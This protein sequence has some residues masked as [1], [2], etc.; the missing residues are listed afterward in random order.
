MTS[1]ESGA[2]SRME[3]DD[4]DRQHFP[5]PVAGESALL[6]RIRSHVDL[7]VMAGATRRGN[8]FVNVF[9]ALVVTLRMQISD[10]LFSFLRSS[11]E[12]DARTRH[13][14]IIE[15]VAIMLDI[16]GHV[17]QLA[18]WNYSDEQQATVKARFTILAGWGR[19]LQSSNIRRLT[20]AVPL[21]RM[22][23]GAQT[24]ITMSGVFTVSGDT[25]S[26]GLT[27]SGGAGSGGAGSGVAG[28][29]VAGS[30]GNTVSGSETSAIKIL[31]GTS[32]SAIA[33]EP[34]AVHDPGGAHSVVECPFLLALL[35]ALQ[36]DS[37]PLL[38]LA[39]TLA[40]A[41]RG[42]WSSD[43]RTFTVDRSRHIGF[44]VGWE[45]LVSTENLPSFG[46]VAVHF[47]GNAIIKFVFQHPWPL[48]RVH[49][50]RGFL[51]EAC[52]IPLIARRPFAPDRRLLAVKDRDASYLSLALKD[53]DRYRRSCG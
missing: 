37:F 21:T 8:C 19:R 51:P 52:R 20:D 3:R 48:V 40:E 9:A 43:L 38:P 23:E 53:W 25:G 12:G 41:A 33:E 31:R 5:A 39:F 44:D 16:C 22:G 49:R 30:G 17:Q 45:W 14:D 1:R 29:G 24:A 18:A 46:V 4:F 36:S 27:M 2:G 6:H 28:S 11:T 13:K 7:R 10:V 26:G 32:S 47:V 50:G 34:R 42:Y 15:G 35:F